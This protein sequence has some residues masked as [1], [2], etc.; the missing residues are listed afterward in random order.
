MSDLVHVSLHVPNELV[1][2]QVGQV[3]DGLDELFDVAQ[4]IP[5][6]AL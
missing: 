4:V 3:G 6:S 2:H 5:T 1:G